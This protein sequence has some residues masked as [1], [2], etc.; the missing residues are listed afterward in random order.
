MGQKLGQASYALGL[1]GPAGTCPTGW[2]ASLKGDDH[3][4]NIVHATALLGLLALSYLAG[5]T[6]SEWK[7]AD[8]AM[9]RVKAS[10]R[11]TIGRE[12]LPPHST[13]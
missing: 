13:E 6:V 8:E 12:V 1:A 4:K 11:V 9:Q 3:L 5:F 7:H 2:P 10:P